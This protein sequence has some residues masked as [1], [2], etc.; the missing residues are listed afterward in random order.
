VDDLVRIKLGPRRGFLRA[1]RAVDWY[2]RGLAHEPHDIEL[3]IHAYRRAIAGRDDFADAHNNLGRLLHERGE[4]DA[5][6]ACYRRALACETDAG[7]GLYHYNLGV[8]LEDRGA[9]D[10]AIAEY[11]HALA[12]DARL[13][14]A[15]FNLARLIEVRAR[16]GGDELL[17]RRAVRHLH[18]YRQLSRVG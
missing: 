3:A 9:V 11:E 18:S 8:V 17:M 13:A 14:D 4:R 2:E 16:S 15:H 7:L 10:E 6:E 5:A 1:K 12:C